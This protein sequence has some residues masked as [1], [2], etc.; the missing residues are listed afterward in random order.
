M[1]LQRSN[2]PNQADNKTSLQI[3][4]PLH[5]LN[6]GSIN[7][8]WIKQRQVH[9]AMN[10]P[11]FIFRCPVMLPHIIA[12]TVTDTDHTIPQSH[13]TAVPVDTVVA[14]NRGDP[15]DIQRSLGQAHQPSRHTTA[16]VQH[17][18][19]QLA[20]HPPKQQ[21]PHSCCQRIFARNIMRHMPPAI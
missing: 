10:H 1:I 14:M 18:R 5:R 3:Q 9:P 21:G 12:D 17:I 20:Q 6:R 19:L 16:G 13:D 11:D 15:R 4:L 8:D 2:S 7:L